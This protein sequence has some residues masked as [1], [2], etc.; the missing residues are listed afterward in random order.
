LQRSLS[1]VMV[2]CN[3]IVTVCRQ[4]INQPPG[5]LKDPA[6]HFVATQKIL[7]T[8]R[9]KRTIFIDQIKTIIVEHFS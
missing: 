1:V 4:E 2:L 7:M 6:R 3:I 9:K 8:S 5:F